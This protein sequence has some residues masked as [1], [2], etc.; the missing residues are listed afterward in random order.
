MNLAKAVS[1]LNRMIEEDNTLEA[2]HQFYDEKVV[3]QENNEP[4]RL[5]KGVCLK[6]EQNNQQKA[7]VLSVN[8]LNQ[9]IDTTTEVVFS[10]WEF[11]FVDLQKSQQYQ[12]QQ[13]SV[14]QWKAEKIVHE[15]FYYHAFI[16][17]S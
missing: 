9:A 4:P 5:G 7:K 1:E 12:L 11:Q 14:Q 3:M 15:R 2:M 16:P 17:V 10:E 6:H 13:V 8:L